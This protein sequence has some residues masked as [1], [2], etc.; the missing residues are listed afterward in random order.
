MPRITVIIPTHNGADRIQETIESLAHQDLPRNEYEVIVV[1]NAS[2]DDTKTVVE[3]VSR[4]HGLEVCYIYEPQLGLHNARHAGARNAR[5]E[6][7]AYTD[8]D[9]ICDKVWLRE[10]LNCYDSDK[11]GCVG[12]KVLPTWE[13]PPPKW[14]LRYPG[15]LALLDHGDEVKELKWP[16]AIYGCNF[17]IR[18]DVLFAVGGFNPDSFGN[19]WLGDGETGLLRKV[20]DAGWKVVYN[21]KAV[22]WHRIPAARLTLDYMKRRFAYQG[23]ADAYTRYHYRGVGRLELVLHG[24]VFMGSAVIF[25]LLAMLTVPAPIAVRHHQILR[26]SYCWSRAGYTLRLLYDRQLQ[27]LVAK[28]RW[29]E[30]DR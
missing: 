2:T 26:A 17:S 24:L 16:E 29:L 7:L 25:G 3:E 13:V 20:Y 6:I 18:R 4:K 10:L 12:G 19:I 8:D 27:A 14:I 1:D 28:E 30:N 15:A 5:G 9:V 21:P 23:A 22:V 11:V